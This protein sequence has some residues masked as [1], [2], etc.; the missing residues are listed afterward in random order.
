MCAGHLSRLIKVHRQVNPSIPFVLCW[1]QGLLEGNKSF[2]GS[3]G[4]RRTLAWYPADMP[5]NEVNVSL[6]ITNTSEWA[7]MVLQD[8]LI[9]RSQ[10]DVLVASCCRCRCDSQPQLVTWWTQPVSQ[11]MHGSTMA[12]GRAGLSR[13]LVYLV[14]TPSNQTSDLLCLCAGVEFTKLGSFG[15]VYTFSQNLVNSMDRSFLLR[16]RNPVAGAGEPVQVAKLLDA[17]DTR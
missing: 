12:P 16:V 2:T 17:K 6:T 10:H 5:A 3:S 9:A 11:A 1:L 8:Q 7:S 15:N 13:E 14:P 4:A